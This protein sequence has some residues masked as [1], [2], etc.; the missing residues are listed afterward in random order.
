[1]REWGGIEYVQD[2]TLRD[3]EGKAGKLRP[4]KG[5]SQVGEPEAGAGLGRGLWGFGQ[6]SF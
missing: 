6:E 2:G 1:M 5:R 3:G 4:T